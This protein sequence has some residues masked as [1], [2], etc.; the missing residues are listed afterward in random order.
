MEEKLEIEYG[1]MLFMGD[2]KIFKLAS[3]CSF[4]NQYEISVRILD[5]VSDEH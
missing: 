1:G 2:E 3:R 4:Y 5:D